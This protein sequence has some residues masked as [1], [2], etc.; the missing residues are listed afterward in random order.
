MGADEFLF[1]LSFFGGLLLSCIHCTFSMFSARQKRW[2][3]MRREEQKGRRRKE[4]KKPKQSF[5][6]CLSIYRE[7]VLCFIRKFGCRHEVGCLLVFFLFNMSKN[8]F[9]C[10]ETSKPQNILATEKVSKIRHSNRASLKTRAAPT[11][12]SAFH[13]S[14]N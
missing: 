2:K 4:G 14:S 9:A 13:I 3:A 10:F 7:K 1:V 8:F 12:N 5:I 11:S 6:P